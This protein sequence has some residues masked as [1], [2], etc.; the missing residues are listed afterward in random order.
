MRASVRSFVPVAVCLILVIVVAPAFAQYRT[1]DPPRTWGDARLRDMD[2]G[3]VLPQLV[4]GGGDAWDAWSSSFLP[5]EGAPP[6]K[7][8]LTGDEDTD[9]EIESDFSWN[10]GA[11]ATMYSARSLMD[12]DPNT[13]WVEGVQGAGEGE[14][15]IALLDGLDR[16]GIRSGFQRSETLFGRN[17]RP[18]RVR[19]FLLAAGYVDAGQYENIYTDITVVG[20]RDVELK[21]A[22][23]WQELPLPVASAPPTKMHGMGDLENTVWFVGIRILSA[24]PGSRWQD[25]CITEIGTME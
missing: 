1:I 4:P 3:L 6:T 17:A 15:V 12:G 20:F 10:Y 19:V 11:W 9:I 25:C 21:D 23:G 2:I 24:F 13:A 16:V 8:A 14:V 7:P 5:A 22:M 18:R